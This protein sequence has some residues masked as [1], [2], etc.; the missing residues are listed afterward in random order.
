M[1]NI[2]QQKHYTQ[3]VIQPMQFVGL[4]K[5]GFIE[6]NVIKYVCRYNLKNGIEDLKKAKHYLE[7]LIEREESGT[8]TLGDKANEESGN[9]EAGCTVGEAG[10]RK[11]RF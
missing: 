10:K 1:K 11:G 9:K 5:I 6:G 2:E 8:I 3:Y 7:K 4:N